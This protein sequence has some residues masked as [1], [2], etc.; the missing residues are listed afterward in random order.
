MCSMQASAS[1][2]PQY[3]RRSWWLI[4][5][6]SGWCGQAGM[7]LDGRSYDPGNITWLTEWALN[8]RIPPTGGLR[9]SEPVCAPVQSPEETR[10]M[11]A[12]KDEKLKNTIP[13]PENVWLKFRSLAWQLARKD[14]P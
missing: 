2:H 6:R 13:P 8:G 1:G 4:L 3:A 11:L 10:R 7:R 12:E 14:K 9:V 5:R